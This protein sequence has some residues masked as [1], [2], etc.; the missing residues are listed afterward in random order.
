MKNDEPSM[1]LMW[2]AV[3]ALA[4]GGGELGRAA[5]TAVEPEAALVSQQGVPT[6]EPE[7]TEDGWTQIQCVRV[8][9]RV[10]GAFE[11]D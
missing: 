4:I 3:I 1:M 7:V 6:F 8:R 9:T 5:A 10:G 11:L 2:L